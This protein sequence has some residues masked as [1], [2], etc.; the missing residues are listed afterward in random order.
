MAQ[1]TVTAN[2]HRQTPCTHRRVHR[3]QPNILNRA[4]RSAPLTVASAIVKLEPSSETERVDVDGLYFDAFTP[5][6]P[7]SSQSY[8]AS[9]ADLVLD[10]TPQVSHFFIQSMHLRNA[11]SARSIVKQMKFVSYK[12]RPSVLFYNSH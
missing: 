1:G 7:T 5:R 9:R 3:T 4:N 11:F 2:A 8:S 10:T 12:G 6:G